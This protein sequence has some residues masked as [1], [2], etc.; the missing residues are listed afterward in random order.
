MDFFTYRFDR[1]EFL[2]KAEKLANQYQNASPFPHIIIDNFF[3]DEILEQVLEEFPSA[4]QINWYRYNSPNERKL[5]CSKEEEFGNKT[6]HFIHLLNSSIFLEFLEKLTGIKNLI[7]D[8]SLEGGGLH[9]IMPGGLL[10][11]HSDFNVH[12]RTKLNRRLNV[13]IYLN[14]DWKEEYGGHFELWDKQMKKCEVKVLP[15][16]NRMAIFSTTSTSYHGHPN[17]LTCP[18]GMSRKSIAM[19]YYTN[20]RPQ[21][22]IQEGLEAHTTLFK[23]RDKNE[24]IAINW[25]IELIA[26]AKQ[27]TPPIL[28][29]KLANL[30]KKN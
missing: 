8:Q 14:K 4:T 30:V 29:R 26:F 23:A 19:Y 27:I 22:E 16:F 18:E 28:Y 21:H 2:E 10:K 5:A 1:K 24:K 15:V 3:P 6:L 20:G 25:R 12:P 17:P 9:Q 13:L 7:P 11:I